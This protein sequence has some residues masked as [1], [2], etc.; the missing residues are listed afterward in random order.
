MSRFVVLL[1][2]SGSMTCKLGLLKQW[3]IDYWL[4]YIMGPSPTPEVAL[5][6]FSNDVHIKSYYT[7]NINDLKQKIANTALSS[8]GGP[9]TSLYDAIITGLTF[10]NPKPD[11]LFVWSDLGDTQSD[12]SESDWQ[13][14]ANS[15]DVEVDLCI[16][17]EW[18]QDQN[19][20][21]FMV[22]ATP[23]ITLIPIAQ[24]LRT[25]KKWSAAVKKLNVIEKPEQFLEVLPYER[26]KAS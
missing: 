18:M 7:T 2:V 21:Q 5:I 11:K 12:A 14:L 15:V 20:S 16:P 8:C 22:I 3:M 17:Y 10:E 4:P 24:T 19:C 9:M 1:D 6:A 23:V 26:K 25:A 13:S